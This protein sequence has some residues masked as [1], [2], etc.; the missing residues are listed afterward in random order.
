MVDMH[1]LQVHRLPAIGRSMPPV[2]YP[3]SKERSNKQRH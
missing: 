2:R 3:S 1:Q